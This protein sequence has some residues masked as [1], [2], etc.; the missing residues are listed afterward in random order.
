MKTCAVISFSDGGERTA[1]RIGSALPGEWAVEY[2]RPRG[3]L[4]SLTAELFARADA[5]VFVGACGIAVRAI[6]PNLVSKDA[7][8]AVAVADERGAFVISLL[9]GHIGGANDLAREI[10]A[11]IGA[12]PVITTATDVSGRFSADAWAAKNGLIIDSLPAAKAFSAAILKRD[13][14]VR[15]DFPILGALPAGLVA[16]D[17]GDVGLR[18]SL[19][20]D[21]PFETTL[22][23]TPRILHLGIG[24]RKGT[25]PEDIGA[26]VA[27]ALDGANLIPG[28]VVSAASIDVKRGEEGLLSWAE[29]RNLPL[30]FY[31]AAELN[32]LEGEFTAS[33]FVMKTVGVDNV[34]ERAACLSAGDGA[35]LLIKK[36]GMRG[37]T[38]ACACQKWSVSFV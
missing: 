6:A 7:D 33:E 4:K 24:C 1:R 30:S 16:G 32:A 15:S 29:G 35:R 19:Y 21:M 38:V 13:L 37:V 22:I 17:S 9:S 11:A 18:I 14:P 5:L 27:A 3:N 10:A 25:A 20:R 26:A 12:T 28:A 36:T 31:S 23:L 2:H 34:C 8:P